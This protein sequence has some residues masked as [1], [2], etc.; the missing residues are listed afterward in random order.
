VREDIDSLLTFA[1]LAV[2]FAGFSSI[3]V[4]FQHRIEGAWT[5]IDAIRFR[6]MI[7]AS[8]FAT[9]FAVL[10]LPV[11][12]LGASSGV[13]WSLCGSALA[14]LLGLGIVGQFRAR[15]LFSGAVAM[16]RWG[17]FQ[18]LSWAAFVAQLLNAFGVFFHRESGPY[19]F[20]VTWLLFCA[21][22]QFYQ[23]VVPERPPVT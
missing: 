7:Q 1:E 5:S 10:P 12:K 20:G 22:W 13:V 17:A 4:L 16:V 9:V 15:R 19:I 11:H 6:T 18:V 14:V 2:A 21:G 3:V 8:L 23:L